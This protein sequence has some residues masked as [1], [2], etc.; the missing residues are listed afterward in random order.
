MRIDFSFSL[1][2]FYESK[3]G[4]P[5]DYLSHR[6]SILAQIRR[7][8]EILNHGDY[9][10]IYL[11]PIG[12]I[13]FPFFKY[14][15]L[16]SLDLLSPE[17][18]FL[19]SR[20]MLKYPTFNRFIDIG[21]NIGL[22]SIVAR[23]IGYSVASFEPDP[24]TFDISKEMFLKND[25]PFVASESPDVILE[26]L[27][28]NSTGLVLVKAAVS[29]Y[30]GETTFTKI[31]DN[32]TANHLI[33]RKSNVYGNTL[34][35]SVRVVRLANF[36][37]NS[38]LKMDAEGEDYVILRSLLSSGAFRGLI[39]LC[40]WRDETRE[41]IYDCLCEYNLNCNN[42]FIEKRF[43]MIQDLPKSKSSDFLEVEV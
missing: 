28:N 20:Y 42:P 11:G 15:T 1:S 7:N 16:T 25:V 34:E 40:D 29:D 2:K 31:L 17:D 24:E 4:V 14:K 36:D 23:R 3:I 26:N 19:F 35:Q 13:N 6:E 39:Y 12:T 18:L 30:D 22:H 5:S 38:I 43:G 37:S 41:K 33:G 27:F 32:P 10:E 8:K 9:V 21:A